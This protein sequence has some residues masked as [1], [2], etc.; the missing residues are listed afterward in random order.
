M[1]NEKRTGAFSLRR[2]QSRQASCSRVLVT[3]SKND[4]LRIFQSCERPAAFAFFQR[5]FIRA[6]TAALA[7]ALILRLPRRD[8][9]GAEALR[10]RRETPR[11]LPTRPLPVVI[12][13]S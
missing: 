2:A 6:E 8:F 9:L 4:L 10:P 1:P 13:S 5:S 11:G 12:A 7:A 3:V